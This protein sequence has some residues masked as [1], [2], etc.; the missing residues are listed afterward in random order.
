MAIRATPSTY[1]QLGVPRCP[2][3]SG[4]VPATVVRR[5]RWFAKFHDTEPERRDPLHV[6]AERP[7]IVTMSA[8]TLDPP[9]LFV[10]IA[11]D[12]AVAA[13]AIV[14]GLLI[15]ERRMQDRGDEDA[16]GR[17]PW[18][19]HCEVG[20]VHQQRQGDDRV[21]LAI[22]PVAQVALFERD[23]GIPGAANLNEPR[24]SVDRQHVGTALLK[25]LSEPSSA[26]PEVEHTL[27]GDVG[28]MP[29]EKVIEPVDVGH[30]RVRLGGLVPRGHVI[31]HVTARY[32]RLWRRGGCVS[33][34][35]RERLARVEF[36]TSE[37]LRVHR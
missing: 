35:H 10:E 36:R 19:D 26:A 27:A 24:T 9:L 20:N 2:A 28:K 21:V 34:G 15:E 6:V 3:A 33:S 18:P 31:G 29:I 4:C 5:G 32:S 23:T 14:H 25:P 13:V 22:D 37:T 17:Q 30:R 8:E 12:F 11:A 7:V 16:A 1:P